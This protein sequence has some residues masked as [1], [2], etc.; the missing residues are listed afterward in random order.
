[1]LFQYGNKET[2][3]SQSYGPQIDNLIGRGYEGLGKSGLTD[4]I[5]G[6]KSSIEPL[7]DSQRWGISL[8]QDAGHLAKRDF[9]GGILDAG[10]GVTGADIQGLMNPYLETVGRS[11]LLNMG[12]EKDNANA[13]IGARNA[14]GVAFGGSGAALERAQL[15]RGHGQNVAQ[16]IAGLL[17]G[18]WDR[19]SALASANADRSVNA[20]I[21]ADG[22]YG[23]MF[24]RYGDAI[25]GLLTTGAIGQAQGQAERDLGWTDWQKFM[26]GLP[27]AGA[28]TTY[29]NPQYFDPLAM[30]VGIGTKFLG[31]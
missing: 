28:T 12:R 3:S 7:N 25:N 20:N 8:A 14:N 17:S 31:F 23:N 10:R 22:A 1:M 19:A 15:E 4:G 30:A 9:S 18:G 5:G 11:T 6:Y 24:G 2:S 29:N 21:A 16:T 26:S 13:A 27:T